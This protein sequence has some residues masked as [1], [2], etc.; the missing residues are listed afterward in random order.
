M[1]FLFHA[2]WFLFARLLEESYIEYVDQIFVS[3]LFGSKN[4]T[5][6]NNFLLF[7]QH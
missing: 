6:Y 7:Y 4:V 1:D 5:K 2:S 3:F